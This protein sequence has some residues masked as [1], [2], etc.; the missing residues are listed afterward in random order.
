MLNKAQLGSEDIA[1]L[2][3]YPFPACVYKNLKNAKNESLTIFQNFKIKLPLC[4]REELYKRNNLLKVE[5]P[6]QKEIIQKIPKTSEIAYP[7]QKKRAYFRRLHPEKNTAYYLKLKELN[8][9]KDVVFKNILRKIK[10]DFKVHFNST[11]RYQSRKKFKS[12][13][14]FMNCIEEYITQILKLEYTQEL[15]FTLGVLINLR[16]IDTLM[17]SNYIKLFTSSSETIDMRLFCLSIA[18]TV[19]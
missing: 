10:K 5:T 15:G 18:L 19:L 8:L 14:I 17:K 7:H 12:I 9:R 4:S 3:L 11:T 13:H 6:D 2:R 16:E 1:N